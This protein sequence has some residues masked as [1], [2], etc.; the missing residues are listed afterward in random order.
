MALN[1]QLTKHP[2]RAMLCGD[3]AAMLSFVGY[4]VH[5]ADKPLLPAHTS[6]LPQ[7]PD[8]QNKK[9]LCR[10]C[11]QFIVLTSTV[12]NLYQKQKISREGQC[13]KGG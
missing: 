13:Q 2:D 5:P 6:V 3:A 4:A 11:C 1:Q 9:S 8:H 12:I 7:H 10:N